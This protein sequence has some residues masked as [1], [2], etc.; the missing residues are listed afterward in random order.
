M[1]VKLP[2]QLEEYL[3]SMVATGLYGSTSEFIR[4]LI[5]K[6]MAEQQ[7]LHNATFYNA[8]RA[9]DEEIFLGKTEPYTNEFMRGIKE[10]AEENI[11]NGRLVKNSEALPK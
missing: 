8:V 5:R 11:K 6:H 7:K 10:Q 2:E 4:E 3:Q 9:G 1:H